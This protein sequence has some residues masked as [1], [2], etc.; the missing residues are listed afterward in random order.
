MKYVVDFNS[1]GLERDDEVIRLEND[2]YGRIVL[3]NS[4]E[5][6]IKEH[7]SKMTQQSILK[8]FELKEIPVNSSVKV[9]IKIGE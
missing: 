9:D 1:W 8:V 7:S 4:I 2:N 5:D 3:Y 6:I